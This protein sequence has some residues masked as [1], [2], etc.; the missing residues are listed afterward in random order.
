MKTQ[1]TTQKK[2]HSFEQK[3]LVC[4][5]DSVFP[6]IRAAASNLLSSLELGKKR[7]SERIVYKFESKKSKSVKSHQMTAALI[8]GKM[9]LSPTKNP[10]STNL[11]LP[12]SGKPNQ[13]IT[14][15]NIFPPNQ[16]AND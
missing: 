13:T 10:L 8:R 3:Q 1:A 15:Q 12:S 5:S 11:A 7:G 14:N 4:T 2:I 16:A 9:V 6:Q